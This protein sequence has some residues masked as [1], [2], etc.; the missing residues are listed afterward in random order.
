MSPL[1]DALCD[2]FIIEVAYVR[3]LSAM[4]PDLGLER[5]VPATGWTVRQTFN[6]IERS[7]HAYPEMFMRLL[8]GEAERPDGFDPEAENA[9]Q[10]AA[11]GATPIDEI[12][13]GLGSQRRRFLG[14]IESHDSELLMPLPGD[15]TVA[16]VVAGWAHHSARHCLEM[17][18]SLP[19]L[20]TDSLVL[21]WLLGSDLGTDPTTLEQKERLRQRAL[22]AFGATEEEQHAS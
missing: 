20:H 15:R 1:G 9:A 10:V 6:H 16:E 17:V 18:E 11:T 12:I 21:T 19:E 8:N 4:I 5:I 3:F 13:A 14:V 7:L 2:R 22:E